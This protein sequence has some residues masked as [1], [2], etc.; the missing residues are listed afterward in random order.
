MEDFIETL[1]VSLYLSEKRELYTS[2]YYYTK[3]IRNMRNIIILPYKI[4]I[5]Q[6]CGNC[7]VRNSSSDVTLKMIS[8]SINIFSSIYTT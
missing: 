8:R 2:K 7:A 4:T 3:G 1:Q 5:S 6:L